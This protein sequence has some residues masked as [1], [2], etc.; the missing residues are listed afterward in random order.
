MT[1]CQDELYFLSASVPTKVEREDTGEYLKSWWKCQ[2]PSLY[3]SSKLHGLGIKN[4]ILFRISFFTV[5]RLHTSWLTEEATSNRI[6]KKQLKMNKLKS[7]PVNVSPSLKSPLTIKIY[8][9]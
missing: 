9:I 6:R 2:Q 5:L 7:S 3:D 4:N 8:R 1:C